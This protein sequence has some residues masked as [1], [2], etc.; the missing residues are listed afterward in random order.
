MCNSTFASYKK[1]QYIDIYHLTMIVYPSDKFNMKNKNFQITKNIFYI[2][3][4]NSNS[5]CVILHTFHILSTMSLILV[6]F[7]S[8]YVK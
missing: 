2:F 1:I 5:S 7:P 6:V 3:Q 8:T 4:L